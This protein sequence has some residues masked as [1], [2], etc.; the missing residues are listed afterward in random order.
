MI[1]SH[2]RSKL[3]AIGD[4]ETKICGRSES[5][6]KCSEMA[7]RKLFRLSASKKNVGKSFRKECNCLP[8]CT[9]IE[10]NAVVSHIKY[11]PDILYQHGM[12]SK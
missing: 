7:E 3:F 10:Y 5:M 8:A 6:I 11:D 2:F 1:E 9:S 4:N 12:K